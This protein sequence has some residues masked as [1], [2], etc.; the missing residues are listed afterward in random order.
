M[1]WNTKLQAF[2]FHISYYATARTEKLRSTLIQLITHQYIDSEYLDKPVLGMG[3]LDLYLFMGTARTSMM[4]HHC[5]FNTPTGVLLQMC[6]EDLALDSGLYGLLWNQEFKFSQWTV[7]R[8]IIFHAC[9]FNHK[10]E[11]VIGVKHHSITKRRN[12]DRSIMVVASEHISKTSSLRA[13]NRVRQFHNVVHLSDIAA[14]DGRGLNHRFV[15]GT[16]FTGKRNDYKW[17][18][19]HHVSESD[20]TQWKIA[21]EYV[22]PL[23]LT[24]ETPLG[25]WE[26]CIAEEWTKNWDWFVTG[27]KTFLYYRETATAWHRFLKNERLHKEYKTTYLVVDHPT[28]SVLRAT[29]ESGHGGLLLLS[30]S[31]KPTIEDSTD[32]TRMIVGSL[33]TPLPEL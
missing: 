22:F 10:H 1:K 19:K 31:I 9:K 24:L 11:I 20:Y 13:I 16:Q 12:N 23:N 29:V 30:T 33:E 32:S 14:A 26:P 18:H 8:S 4:I 15:A 3:V 2:F 5:W 6:I 28:E 21:M 27:D 7:K 25:P 17:P